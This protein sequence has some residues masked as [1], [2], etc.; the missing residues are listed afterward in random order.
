MDFTAG[1]ELSHLSSRKQNPQ[2]QFVS[3]FGF[4]EVPGLV[5]ALT[6]Q[7]ITETQGQGV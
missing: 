1:R 4:G 3:G 6:E 7:H 5:I 2:A